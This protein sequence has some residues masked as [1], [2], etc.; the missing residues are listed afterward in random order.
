[1]KIC[2][3]PGCSRKHYGNG[4]CNKHHLQIRKHGKILEI[5]RTD[6]NRV[7]IDGE[8]CHLFLRN[9]KQIEI[10]ETLIDL[11]FLPIL[12]DFKW[13]LTNGGYV[14]TSW[15]DEDGQRCVGHLHQ[16]IIQL[17]GQEVPDGYEIDHKDRDSLNNRLNNLRFCTRAQNVH[18]RERNRNNTS[19]YIGVFWDNADK[20]WRAKIWVN[21]KAIHLGNFSIKED[22]AR[23]YNAAAIFYHGE[24]AVLNDV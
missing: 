6:P 4:Y 23:A 10:A 13:W 16:A 17:S 7:I 20:K 19:G 8:T 24:F 15:H 1:M 12:K 22:A 11:E 18:N 2:T 21:G 3:V 9:R 5:T 14:I